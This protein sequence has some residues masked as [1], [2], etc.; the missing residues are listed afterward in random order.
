MPR[1]SKTPSP[2]ARRLSWKEGRLR[3]LDETVEDELEDDE[4]VIEEAAARIVIIG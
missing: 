3:V 2:A 1:I 4:D